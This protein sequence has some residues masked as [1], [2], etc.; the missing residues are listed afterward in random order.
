MARPGI[1]FLVAQAKALKCAQTIRLDSS[2]KYS[3][4]ICALFAK[5]Q[6]EPKFSFS[7]FF[8]VVPVLVVNI[9]ETEQVNKMTL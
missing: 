9:D 8:Q 7:T 3:V 4:Q 6:S 1:V 2:L 5:F